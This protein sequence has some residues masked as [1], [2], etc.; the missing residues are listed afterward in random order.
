MAPG[1]RQ[2]GELADGREVVGGD[3]AHGRQF[4]VEAGVLAADCQIALG[5]V[6][7]GDRAGPAG[8]G[9]KTDAAGVG[10]QVEHRLAGAM[11]LDPATGV[12]QVEEQQRILAGMARAHPVVEPPFVTDQVGQRLGSGLEHRVAAVDARVALRAVVVHRQQRG[13]EGLL[14]GLQ[15]FQQGVALERLMEALHQQLRAVAVDGQAGGTF[16]AAVEQSVAV[17]ALRVQFGEQ[18]LAGVEGGAQRLVQGG[19][20]RL[21]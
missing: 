17:G 14:A 4:G 2:A 12:A 13:G 3:E 5:E 16:L 11:A 15:Q 21:L 18:G 1:D 8:C 9:A 20:A 10:E 6:E 7:V 19:H